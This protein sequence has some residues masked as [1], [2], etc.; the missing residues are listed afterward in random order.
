[1]VF[2]AERVCVDPRAIENLKFGLCM[3]RIP[4]WLTRKQLLLTIMKLSWQRSQRE[5]IARVIATSR[6]DAQL[7]CPSQA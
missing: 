5:K 1:M 7:P 3:G 6:H 2:A 4:S